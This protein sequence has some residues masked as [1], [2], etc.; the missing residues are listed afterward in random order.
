MPRRICIIFKFNVDLSSEPLIPSIAKK[1]KT[2]VGIDDKGRILQY[3]LIGHLF[4][5]LQILQMN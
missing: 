4:R 2:D 3:T 5:R 1:I